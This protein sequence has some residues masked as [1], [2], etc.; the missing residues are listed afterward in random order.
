MEYV[1]CSIIYSSENKDTVVKRN[2][3]DWYIETTWMALDSITSSKISQ[4][5][6]NTIWFLYA[7]PKKTKQ[8]R[9]H[10]NW[11]TDPEDNWVVATGKRVVRCWVK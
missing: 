10:E 5:K 3:G 6:R 7:K 4:I 2:K 9:Q 8:V 1:H 11:L